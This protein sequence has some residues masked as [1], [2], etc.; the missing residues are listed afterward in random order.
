MRMIPTAQHASS[1]MLGFVLTTVG[2]ETPLEIPC[3]MRSDRCLGPH[4]CTLFA[5]VPNAHG[6]VAL[7]VDLHFMA[8]NTP[9]EAALDVEVLFEHGY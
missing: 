1:N 3:P 7:V 9:H 4:S 2:A 5:K 8:N 6:S